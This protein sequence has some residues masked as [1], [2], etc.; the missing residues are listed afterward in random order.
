VIFRWSS[1]G[2]Q[3]LLELES[4]TVD[5]IDNPT[6][7]DF[8]TIEANPDLKLYP[9]E[10]LNVFYVGFNRDYAPFDDEKVRQAMAMGIDRQ[11]IVDN[12]Y[13]WAR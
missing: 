11:R 6:P 13:R 1:E 10:A 4:G 12:F 7:D 5:G 9:R 8:A 2:A 3:R